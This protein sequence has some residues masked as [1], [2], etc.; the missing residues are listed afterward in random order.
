MFDKVTDTVS[1]KTGIPMMCG[2]I[3]TELLYRNEKDEVVSQLPTPIKFNTI[4]REIKLESTN[5]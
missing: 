5:D 2:A 3:K 1:K 4:K